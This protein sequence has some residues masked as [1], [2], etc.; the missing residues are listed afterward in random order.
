MTLPFRHRGRF[1]KDEQG[2]L[3]MSDYAFKDIKS[4]SPV[5][6]TDSSGRRKNT[7]GRNFKA[8]VTARDLNVSLI[9]QTF[10]F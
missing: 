5:H 2:L 7:G 6:Q 9:Y 3:Y 1:L 8:S 4:F 10:N